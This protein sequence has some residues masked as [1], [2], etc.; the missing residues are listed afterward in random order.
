MYKLNSM[1][2]RAQTQH[3]AIDVIQQNLNSTTLAIKVK[4]QGQIPPKSNHSFFHFG[5]FACPPHWPPTM[6]HL[7]AKFMHNCTMLAY[8]NNVTLKISGTLVTPSLHI[9]YRR[10]SNIARFSKITVPNFYGSS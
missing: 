10:M 4:G 9:F 6:D 3:A 8:Y 2:Y 5:I 7:A 1:S